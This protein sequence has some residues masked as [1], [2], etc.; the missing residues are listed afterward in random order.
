MKK[1]K[2]NPTKKELAIMKLYWDMFKA[3]E[4]LFWAKMGKLE[5]E[6]SKQTGIEELEFFQC[7][8]DWCGIGQGNREMR[9]IHREELA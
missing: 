4:S 5:K 6:M 9:L 8:G 3:E 2:I 7:D 1:Y